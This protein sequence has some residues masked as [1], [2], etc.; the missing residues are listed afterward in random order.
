MD[1]EKAYNLVLERAE[2]FIEN[3]DEREKTIAESIFAGLIETEDEK[4]INFIMHQLVCIRATLRNE[5]GDFYTELTN[6][7]NWLEKQRD[8]K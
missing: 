5:G 6:A 1:Y 4:M 7:I 8:G 3:G 2:S